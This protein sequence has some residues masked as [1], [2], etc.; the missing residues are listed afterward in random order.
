[1]NKRVFVIL[2]AFGVM[3]SVNIT[4]PV[5][6][7]GKSSV[8]Y[9]EVFLP[10]YMVAQ[11]GDSSPYGGSRGGAYGEKR[12]VR[13]VEDAQKLLREYFSKRDVK[14]GEIREKEYHFEADI[15]DKNNNLID[16]VIIDKRTGRIRSIY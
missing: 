15:R 7:E 6:V 12:E 9:A 8:L 1:M 5:S 4:Y 2:L 14:I 10:S 11:Q 13:T 16:K 3:A